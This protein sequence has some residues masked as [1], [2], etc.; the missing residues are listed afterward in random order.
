[1]RQDWLLPMQYI[2][3]YTNM[4]HAAFAQPLSIL[5]LPYVWCY[6]TRPRAQGMYECS[7][8]GR[9]IDLRLLSPISEIDLPKI[10]YHPSHLLPSA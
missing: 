7:R 3:P 2:V 10:P 1:M 6:L 5:L 4:G 9:M 8:D